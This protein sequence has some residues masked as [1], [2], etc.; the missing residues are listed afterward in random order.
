MVE[1]D[2]LATSWGRS[3]RATRANPPNDSGAYGAS[4]VTRP[5][6]N[7]PRNASAPPQ[8]PSRPLDHESKMGP[9]TPCRPRRNSSAARCAMADHPCPSDSPTQAPPPL[10]RKPTRQSKQPSPPDRLTVRLWRIIEGQAEGRFAIA[11]LVI[12]V[13]ATLAVG[14]LIHFL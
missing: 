13:V 7:M 3:V 11:A 10:Q 5:L 9:H 8:A 12:V 14:A 1:R 6:S 4:T 2:V